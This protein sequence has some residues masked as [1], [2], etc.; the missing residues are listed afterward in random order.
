MLLTSVLLFILYI[1]TRKSFF[2]IAIVIPALLCYMHDISMNA[3]S[4]K[5]M[6]IWIYLATLSVLF[7]PLSH[8]SQFTFVKIATSYYFM[9]FDKENY[10]EMAISFIAKKMRIQK[11]KTE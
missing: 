4:R 7:K 10:L 9:F 3:H 11:T 1:F 2:D 5:W 8:I 6:F